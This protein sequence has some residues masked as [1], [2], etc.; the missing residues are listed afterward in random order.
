MTHHNLTEWQGRM[1]DFV[2]SR[3]PDDPMERR[4]LIFGE[5]GGEVLQAAMDFVVAVSKVQRCILKGA[6]DIRGGTEHWHH[7]LRKE[8]AQAFLVL[9][10]LAHRGDFSLAQAV[11][12]EWERTKDRIWPTGAAQDGGQADG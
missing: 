1:A 2:D 11:A 5:E 4:G 6:Q 12:E 3:W 10:T 9:C 8:T 7:E